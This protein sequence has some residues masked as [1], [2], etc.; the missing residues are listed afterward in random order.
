[1]SENNESLLNLVN[2]SGYLLQ[3]RLESYI[4]DNR[5]SH[6]WEIIG[7]EHPWINQETGDEGFIDIVL[8]S[9]FQQVFRMVIECKRVLDSSWVF[10]VTNQ[11]SMNVHRSRLYWSH[12]QVERKNLTGWHDFGLSPTFPEAGFCVVR[13]QSDK[14]KPML[15]RIA[16]ILLKSVESLA[17]EESNFAPTQPSE[18][19]VYIPVIITTA[20]LEVCLV[21]P[22]D[23]NIENGQLPDG[24][25]HFEKVPFVAFR[26]G[27]IVNNL[28][29]TVTNLKK[30][31]LKKEQT[32]FIVQA[33]EVLN[34]LNQ[35]NKDI[36]I[37]GDIGEFR[38]PWDIAREQEKGI[39][40]SQ[41]PGRQ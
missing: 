10:L 8:G 37:L 27:M 29:K 40:W 32:V 36:K 1:M 5:T 41:A 30:A 34:F 35:V 39:A 12:C 2:S 22:S 25:G 3:L 13:G 18:A 26:K 21:D 14:D 15:E 33:L 38:P 31:N 9:Q 11:K 17:E 7:H 28:G 20:S 16:G 19:H 24:K 23:V 6:G 4:D